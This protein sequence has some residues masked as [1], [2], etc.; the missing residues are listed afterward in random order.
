MSRY[1]I[2]LLVVLALLVSGCGRAGDPYGRRPVRGTVELDGT[3]L[4]AGSIVFYPAER[5]PVVSG[6]PVTEGRFE[7]PAAQGLPAGNYKVAVTAAEPVSTRG[8]SAEELMEHPPG[9]KSLIPAKYN[10]STTLKFEVNDATENV[11]D[12][13]L[14]SH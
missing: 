4:A 14:T 2:L 12:L 10:T 1:S 13:K 6:V 7:I 8:M 11:C 5:G 9:A 3:P